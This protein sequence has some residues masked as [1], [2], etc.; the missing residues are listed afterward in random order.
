M[1]KERPISFNVDMMRALLAG[2]KTQTRRLMKP[3][4][5]AKYDRLY[6]EPRWFWSQS[7]SGQGAE[8]QDLL[9]VPKCP[10]GRPGD[11]LW[12]REPWALCGGLDQVDAHRLS[13]EWWSHQIKMGLLWHQA[14]DDAP[15]DDNKTIGEQM[16]SRGRWR[17]CDDMP[18][19]ASRITLE[20]KAIRIERLQDISETDA[21]AEGVEPLH[22]NGD[23][24]LWRDYGIKP[25]NNEGYNYFNAARESFASLIDSIK[26]PGTWDSN[27]WVRVV[28]F[29]EIKCRNP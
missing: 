13:K 9:P 17:N 19:W 24:Q 11:R 25:E 4:P 10:Y 29:E 3:Q 8:Q 6:Y 23:M 14:T 1:I 22:S 15:L 21:I 2:R 12:C 16:A 18:R 20:I 5:P 27:P 28:E 7:T 26:G